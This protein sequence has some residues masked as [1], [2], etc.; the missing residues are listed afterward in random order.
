M[1]NFWNPRKKNMMKVKKLF[2]MEIFFFQMSLFWR[3][4]WGVLEED[5]FVYITFHNI[6]ETIKMFPVVPIEVL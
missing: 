2:L 3:I 4:N 1:I 5:V 6:V